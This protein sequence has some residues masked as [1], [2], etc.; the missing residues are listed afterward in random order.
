MRVV[1]VGLAVLLASQV[2][3]AAPPAGTYEDFGFDFLR[4]A[5]QGNAVAAPR[6][7]GRLLALVASG[8]KGETQREL[9]AALRK[10]RADVEG[11][12]KAAPACG[13]REAWAFA[14]RVGFT[15]AFQKRVDDLS[16]DR[17]SFS[18][19]RDETRDAIDRWARERTKGEIRDLV[20][21]D[22]LDDRSML[23]L[24]A[25]SEFSSRWQD[26][27]ETGSTRWGAFQLASGEKVDVPMMS[28]RKNVRAAF[29]QEV[30]ILELPF[31][32]EG[33]AAVVL[34]PRM[35]GDGEM[36]SAVGALGPL[37]PLDNLRPAAEAAPERRPAAKVAR[38]PDLG[39]LEKMLSRETLA[40]WRSQLGPSLVHV[41]L[42]RFVV[43]S[44]GNADRALQALGIRR[45]FKS[46]ADFGAMTTEPLQ[47]E[48]VFHE[49]VV[50]VAEGG[51]DAWAGSAVV[52]G[53]R[54]SPPPVPDFR[55]D[56]PFLFL[57]QDVRSGEVL[58][59][60]RVVDPR[61]RPA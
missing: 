46:G 37:G 48:H 5:D 28:G 18:S 6:N 38:P 23:V 2:A 47:I 13:Q 10:T 31:A 57:I 40:R 12:T 45:A 19:N 36:R 35:P 44:N 39:R 4:T 61:T 50:K 32:C 11:L 60:A 58:F 8:A 55:V 27:F 7:L 42:P 21:K 52:F 1:A 54:G 14:S 20:P 34:M 15:D 51:V 33:L 17:I 59:L 41:E 22:G 56:R 16:A 24:A 53:S 25:V 3:V 9:L 26:E 49:A 43:R 30:S 29:L